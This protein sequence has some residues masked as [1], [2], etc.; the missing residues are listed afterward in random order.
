MQT[1]TKKAISWF[2]LACGGIG[3]VLWVWMLVTAGWRYPGGL[4]R[5]LWPLLSLAAIVLPLLLL[6]GLYRE[7]PRQLGGR[8]QLIESMSAN[9]RPVRAGGAGKCVG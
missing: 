6:R 9:G 4:A 1:G 3:S 8:W 2:V 5:V 7:S